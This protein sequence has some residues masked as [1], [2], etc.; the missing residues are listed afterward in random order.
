MKLTTIIN[1]IYSLGDKVD[2]ISIIKKFIRAVPSR[3]M[4]IVT[5]IE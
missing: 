3:F 2:G 1:D 4:Q 5:S